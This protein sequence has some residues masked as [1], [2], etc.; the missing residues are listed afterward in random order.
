MPSTTLT[1]RLDQEE[2]NL[3]AACAELNRKP[4][5]SIVLDSVLDRI[6]DEMDIKLYQQAKAEFDKDQIIHLHTEAGQ[7][8][9]I[10]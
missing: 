3:I 6:E 10:I 2:R 9:G 4:I 5:A 8:L 7:E 1:I